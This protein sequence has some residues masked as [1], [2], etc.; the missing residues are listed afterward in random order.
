MN[1]VAIGIHLCANTPPETLQISVFVTMASTEGVSNRYG[2]W[3]EDAETRQWDSPETRRVSLTYASPHVKQYISD[4]HL[5]NNLHCH[6]VL[7]SEVI[8]I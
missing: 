3:P 8:R 6:H 4:P 2:V 5:N 7:P 1:A